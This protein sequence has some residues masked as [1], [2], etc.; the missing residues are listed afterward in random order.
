MQRTFGGLN[1]FA[2]LASTSP[3]PGGLFDAAQHLVGADSTE[4]RRD[5]TEYVSSLSSS[6]AHAKIRGD[7]A[8]FITDHPTTNGDLVNAIVQPD[9]PP[10][11]EW[12]A[13]W[14]PREKD[15]E[16]IQPTFLDPLDESQL[17][18]V[19]EDAQQ[20][21][22]EQQ[23]AN[24]VSAAN[25]E[26]IAVQV[27][28]TKLQ[29]PIHVHEA[30]KTTTYEP[31]GKKRPRAGRTRRCTCTPPSSSTGG[32]PTRMSRP[33]RPA[34]PG[35]LGPLR[36]RRHP[37]PARRTPTPAMVSRRWIQ[38]RYTT[39]VPNRIIAKT[40]RHPRSRRLK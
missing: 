34:P 32:L 18:K 10:T 29:S 27:L 9:K 5:V 23:K 2:N 16:D 6:T 4:L 21:K 3:A 36:R 19:R 38:R 35:K 25:A 40:Q 37:P 24:T 11:F 28:A 8:D 20:E 39:T 22:V 13:H 14:S 30:G 26:A 17:A 7:L 15:W 31:F 12:P 33:H 1:H